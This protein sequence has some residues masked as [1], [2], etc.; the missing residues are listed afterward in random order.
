MAHIPWHQTKMEQAIAILIE[1]PCFIRELSFFIRTVSDSPTLLHWQP[2][3]TWVMLS[4]LYFI[5]LVDDGILRASVAY[6]T[7]S[8]QKPP[9]M[10]SRYDYLLWWLEQRVVVPRTIAISTHVKRQ[11]RTHLIHAYEAHSIFSYS[12]Y[13]TY[14]IG[15]HA[16]WDRLEL[17][18][19]VKDGTHNHEGN[20]THAAIII[21]SHCSDKTT[22][23][24]TEV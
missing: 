3:S 5:H 7:P 24:N 22:L 11:T 8:D 15:V 16:C 20:I 21:T 14:Y 9:R 10:F 13:S 4:S 23:L 6:P 12:T 2:G 19:V 1:A 17:H 18:I